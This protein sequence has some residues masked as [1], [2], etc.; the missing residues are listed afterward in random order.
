MMKY[1]FFILVLVI[2]SNLLYA[3]VL[4]EYPKGQD[5]Y[6]GGRQGL[7]S[8]V[9]QI[10]VK[11]QMRSCEKTEAL[12]MRFVVYPDA[13]IKYVSD[14]DK[15]AEENNK[16]LKEKV[17]DVLK[18]VKNWKPAEVNGQKN[19]VMVTM[20]FHD[21]LLFNNRVSDDAFSMPIYIYKDKESNIMKFRE[22]FA[23]CFDTNGY[24]PIG[25][26]SFTIN[27]DIDTNGEAG[28]FYIENQSTLDKF[29]EMVVR[30]ATNSKKAYWK[31]GYYKSVPIKQVFKMPIKFAAN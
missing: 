28:F 24:R 2:I 6:K 16:C 31:P 5:F 4:Y 23:K 29:N 14:S 21:D 20:L 1:K 7:Y 18:D 26:Y 11:K 30:C 15:N 19:A 17:L 3:Q 8:E 13:T 9:Q 22:N 25:D 12:L 27:F 10:V